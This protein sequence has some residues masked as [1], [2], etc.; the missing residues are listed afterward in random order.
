MLLPHLLRVLVKGY[1]L[2][3]SWRMLKL[4][5][6]LGDVKW[7]LI[8]TQSMQRSKCQLFLPF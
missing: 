5:T 4:R 3:V 8:V 2:S 6:P 1:G 7:H